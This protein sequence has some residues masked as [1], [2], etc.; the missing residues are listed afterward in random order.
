MSAGGIAFLAEHEAK[1][2]FNSL[3]FTSLT[4]LAAGSASG[5][6]RE[7]DVVASA[8]RGVA[9]VGCTGVVIQ[10]VGPG[11]V[12]AR[13]GDGAVHVEPRVCRIDRRDVEILRE[14][15]P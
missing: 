15:A 10:T 2:R 11:L 9:E 1:R 14:R 7:V 8:V 6:V 4:R 12:E 5:T 13:T 3:A